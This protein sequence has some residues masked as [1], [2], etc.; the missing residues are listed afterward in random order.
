MADKD[1]ESHQ[2]MRFYGDMRFKQL[3]LY[4]AWITVAVAGISQF[5]TDIFLSNAS[6]KLVISFA[7]MLITAVIWIM[8][9]SSTK[10]WVAFK[11]NLSEK[12]PSSGIKLK[13]FT[14]TN[15]TMFLYLVSYLFWFYAACTW[16]G[17]TI[18]LIIYAVIGLSIFIHNV[19]NYWPL[20]RH[21][22]PS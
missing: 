6:V 4:L 20:W 7:S 16:D 10:Y 18:F 9:I 13:L 14:A 22:K 1:T 19:L 17:N 5:G 2:N 3:T 15:A 8:E 21:S 12:T 11:E